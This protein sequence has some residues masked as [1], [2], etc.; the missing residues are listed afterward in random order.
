MLYIALVAA[1]AHTPTGFYD[2]CPD[3]AIHIHEPNVSQVFYMRLR[4]YC[5]YTFVPDSPGLQ[6]ISL[7]TFSALDP[8]AGTFVRYGNT[9]VIAAEQER[10]GE[11]FTSTPMTT[12]VKEENIYAKELVVGGKSGVVAFVSGKAEEWWLFL[13]IPYFA[14]RV[15]W[16]WA[17]WDSAFWFWP[18][19]FY[20]IICFTWPRRPAI[21]HTLF[22]LFYILFVDIIVPCVMTAVTLEWPQSG[23]WSGVLAARV[24]LYMIYVY[25]VYLF[26]WIR[27]GS[28][29]PYQQSL[30]RN[31]LAV[32]LFLILWFASMILGIGSYIL[33]PVFFFRYTRIYK[34]DCR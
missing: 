8:S 5:N 3:T 31:W 21:L 12:V 32:C 29:G 19:A 20:L 17:F 27:V 4:S 25:M 14:Q 22:L 10:G 33:T 9:T 34:V 26:E 7:H 18:F 6:V 15:Q 16:Q 11:P 2:T 13:T 24:V 23:M 1:L 28:N 30:R